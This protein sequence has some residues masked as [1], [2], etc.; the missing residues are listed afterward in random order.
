VFTRRTGLIGKAA[1]G[2]FTLF[3]Q[4]SWNVAVFARSASLVKRVRGLPRNAENRP[5]AGAPVTQTAIATQARPP[6]A[7]REQRKRRRSRPRRRSPFSARR[8][9]ACLMQRFD[10]FAHDC[11]GFG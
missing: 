5:M 7:T 3:A 9:L 4:P 1:K 11:A 10:E 6:V 2:R 8:L